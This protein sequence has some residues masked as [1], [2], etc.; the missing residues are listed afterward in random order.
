MAI[1]ANLLSAP[2]DVEP[3]T[4]STKIN[5][6]TDSAMKAIVTLVYPL[7]PVSVVTEPESLAS[8]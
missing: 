4:T 3:N 1:P 5:V 8:R 2:L 7:A 6:K